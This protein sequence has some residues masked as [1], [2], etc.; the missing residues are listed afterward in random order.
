M[1]I[2][3]GNPSA[4]VLPPVVN[5]LL[6]LAWIA[7]FAGRW[8]LVQLLLAAGVLT[9]SNVSDLDN[10][11]LVY[12]YLALLTVTIAVAVLRAMRHARPAAPQGPTSENDEAVPMSSS[13]ASASSADGGPQAGD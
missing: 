9:P 3:P 7:L 1:S 12:C 10:R 5:D 8:I 6:G 13:S 11:F 4:D 2:E